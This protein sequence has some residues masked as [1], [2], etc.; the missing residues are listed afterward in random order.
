MNSYLRTAKVI[1]VHPE[2]NSADIVYT[3]TGARVPLVQIV[4]DYDRGGLPTPTPPADPEKPLIKTKKRDV[5]AL[6][7]TLRGDIPVIVGFLKPQVHQVLFKG[8]EDFTVNDHASGV[9]ETIEGDGSVTRRWP[10]GT[11]LKVGADPEAEDLGGKD[12]DEKWA[13]ERNTDVDPHVRLVVMGGGEVKAQI[14]ISP[15]GAVSISMSGQLTLDVGADALVNV[16]GNAEVTV[17]GDITSSAASW[18]HTGDINVT[19]TVD[20]SVDV[21][22]G[23]VSLKNHTHNGVHGP[24]SPPV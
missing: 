20:A 11:Y 23:G 18:T 12:F 17:A 15:E 6:V 2:A 4:G 1:K 16:A 13:R 10:N 19:G 7:G 8:R 9:Y 3:D 5:Y 21:I 22:G 24:T 14:D